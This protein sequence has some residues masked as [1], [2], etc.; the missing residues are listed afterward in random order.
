MRESIF[1]IFVLVA[2]P[3]IFGEIVIPLGKKP[4]DN[5]PRE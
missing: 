5:L 2:L 3:I 1:L 4:T